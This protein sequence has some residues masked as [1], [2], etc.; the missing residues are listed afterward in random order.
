M[1]DS[2]LKKKTDLLLLE[3]D[4][5]LVVFKNL[6]VCE[7][8]P[9]VLNLF[10]GNLIFRFLGHLATTFLEAAPRPLYLDGCDVVHRESVVLE[11]T[12]C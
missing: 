8:T 7:G 2:R 10:S 11:K 3:I 9:G 1:K 12:S 6:D 5:I 4:E